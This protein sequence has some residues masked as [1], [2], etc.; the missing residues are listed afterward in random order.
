MLSSNS[1]LVIADKIIHSHST[2]LH[3]KVFRG[4]SKLSEKPWKTLGEGRDW[5]PIQVEWIYPLLILCTLYKI[6]TRDVQCRRWFTLL[7]DIFQHKS[8]VYY[9]NP[10][11]YTTLLTAV[12]NKLEEN[13]HTN[14][15]ES[16]DWAGP[17]YILLYQLND[18]KTHYFDKCHYQ[19]DY[20][21]M[22]N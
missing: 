19:M 5:H 6:K 1:D 9:P 15:Q 8:Y 11:Y 12:R 4:S 3:P 14:L 21:L 7:Q 16:R 22:F 13:K 18:H 20:Q 17:L 2:Y 10:K